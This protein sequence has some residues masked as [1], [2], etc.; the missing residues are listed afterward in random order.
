[1]CPQRNLQITRTAQTIEQAIME[2]FSLQYPVII[3]PDRSSTL[4]FIRV[5]N[6]KELRREFDRVRKIS[7]TSTVIMRKP[8]K[9]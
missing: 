8:L 1:M 7:P 5:N 2:M 3:M 4:C 6:L 9:A